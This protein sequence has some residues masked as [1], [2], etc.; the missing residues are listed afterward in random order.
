MICENSK[1]KTKTI[2]TILIIVVIALVVFW[3][4]SSEESTPPLDN[5][6]VVFCTLDAMQCPDGS[7][8]GRVAPDCNFAECPNGN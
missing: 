6:D 1:V 2:Y 7:F 8:V 4:Y 3:F 5:D